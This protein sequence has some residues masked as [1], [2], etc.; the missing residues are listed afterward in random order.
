AGHYEILGETYA[1]FEFFENDWNPYS[2]FLDVDKVDLILRRK[3]TSGRKIYREIQV[4]FGK[5]HNVGSAWE[6]EHFDFS[7]FRFFKENEFAGQLDQ[8]DFF[9]AYILARD[10]G[11]NRD[12]FIFPI[13]DFVEKIIQ[14]AIPSKDQRKVYIS[15][16]KGESERWVLRRTG[17]FSA[18]TDE[19]CLDVSGYRRNF[20]V[21]LADIA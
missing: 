19:T 16:M 9:I 2:R 15:R 4:K 10:S 13:R 11:Y 3:L 7:S 12:I 17:R 8:K 20:S 18:V 14:C 1:K 5:L 6:K 21:L